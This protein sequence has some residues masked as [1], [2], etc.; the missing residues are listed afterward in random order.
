MLN[1]HVKNQDL[2]ITEMLDF[3]IRLFD[4]DTHLTKEGRLDTGHGDPIWV[5]FGKVKDAL[6]EINNWLKIHTNE[7]VIIYFGNRL[8][9][10]TEGNKELRVMLETEFNGRSVGLNDH[11]QKHKEW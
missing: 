3:G 5:W 8:G 7:I 4:I 10:V 2:N 9:N 6:I 11:W 1:C